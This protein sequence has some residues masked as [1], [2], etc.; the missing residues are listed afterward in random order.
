MDFVQLQ[1]FMYVSPTVKTSKNY[2]LLQFELK[3]KWKV[4]EV[5][6]TY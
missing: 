1:L 6:S 4:S 3:N 5:L 2:G